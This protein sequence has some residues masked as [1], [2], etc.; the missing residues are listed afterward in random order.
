MQRHKFARN[1]IKALVGV[2]SPCVWT[3]SASP[4]DAVSFSSSAKAKVRRGRLCQRRLRCRRL[5]RRHR[6]RHVRCLRGHRVAFR[7]TASP[8]AT[9][10]SKDNH[11]RVKAATLASNS[12]IVVRVGFF[13]PEAAA[14]SS[15]TVSADAGL[16]RIVACHLVTRQLCFVVGVI[17][18]GCLGLA[19]QG[20]AHRLIGCGAGCPAFAARIV[21]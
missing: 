2:S 9:C 21:R 20:L 13:F 1:L 18:V 17:F 12:S 4:D 7:P 6:L 14:P 16:C 5:L 8:V 15:V 10:S 19:G 11:Q 3:D